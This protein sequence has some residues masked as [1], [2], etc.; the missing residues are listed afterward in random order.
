MTNLTLTEKRTLRVKLSDEKKA[1]HLDKMANLIKDNETLEK[2]KKIANEEFNSTIKSND[3]QLLA[4]A[5]EVKD[6]ASEEEIDC[7]WITDDPNPGEKTLYR[8]DTSEKVETV[9]VDLFDPAKPAGLI[10]DAEEVAYTEVKESEEEEK[11]INIPEE[12][13]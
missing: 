6:L 13:S 9:P 11:I 1:M 2:E 4:L 10:G 3:A 12:N 8:N 5:N 7:Y